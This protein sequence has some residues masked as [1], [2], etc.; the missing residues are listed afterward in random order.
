MAQTE[1]PWRWL[2]DEV[3]EAYGRPRLS[4]ARRADEF[5]AGLVSII[6][7][8]YNN[9]A[10]IAAAIESALGQTH[11][12]REVLVIDDGSRDNSLEIIKGYGDR[13]QWRTKSNGGAPAARNDGLELARGEYIQFLDGDDLLVADAVERRLGAMSEDCDAVFGDEKSIDERG[14]FDGMELKHRA[15]EWPPADMAEYIVMRNIRTPQPLHR[16]SNVYRVG[17][18]DEALPRSQ[19]PDFHLRMHF[20]GHRFRHLRA[21]VSLRREHSH[22]SRI[23]NVKWMETDPDRYIKLIRHWAGLLPPEYFRQE[24]QRL[25]RRLADLLCSKASVA[26]AAGYPEVGT[27]Y[28]RVLC[29]AFPGYRPRGLAGRVSAILGLRWGMR[30]RRMESRFLASKMAGWL[31]TSL[32][33]GR[34]AAE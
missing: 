30:A 15:P 20:G 13:I 25:P 11:A 33:R 28:A 17:G 18:F 1:S 29:R 3:P 32:G 10:F 16:R 21:Y 5:E 22:A 7:P 19:E 23:R 2:L 14:A 9:G 34:G 6:I 8:C 12:K 24:T 27:N 26:F 4:L 31:R